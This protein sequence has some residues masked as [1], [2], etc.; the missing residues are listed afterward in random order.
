MD[1]LR[2][3]RGP[4][5]AG[6]PALVRGDLATLDRL[7]ADDWVGIDPA[8]NTT[9]KRASLEAIRGG[10]YRA[11]LFQCDDISVRLF[12]ETAIVSVRSTV[13]ATYDGIDCSGIYR[14]TEVWIKRRGR[15]QCVASHSSRLPS[16]DAV[17][18]TGANPPAVR[19]PG[20]HAPSENG[21]P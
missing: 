21:R 20:P 9:T 16:P 2:I 5:H 6:G 1:T 11:T 13:Q 4:N 10:H 19:S 8:G 7:E 15:W 14:F 3:E 17:Q 12:G 18:G